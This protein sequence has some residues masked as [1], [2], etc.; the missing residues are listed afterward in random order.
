MLRRT[1][2]ALYRINRAFQQAPKSRE[3]DLGTHNIG[4]GKIVHPRISTTGTLEG[5]DPSLR[6]RLSASAQAKPAAKPTT[7]PHLPADNSC[8]DLQRIYVW[9]PLQEVAARQYACAH[10]LDPD[11]VEC[12]PDL[13]AVIDRSSEIHFGEY[14]D[15]TTNTNFMVYHHV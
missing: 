5:L 2:T 9:N 6:G 14:H 3:K 11:I 12:V 13:K 15:P 7:T 10:G 4:G 8:T 1:Q